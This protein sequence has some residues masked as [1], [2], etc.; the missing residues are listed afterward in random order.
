MKDASK[1]S[2]RSGRSH[3]RRVLLSQEPIPAA[4]PIRLLIV[5]DHAVVLGG[6]EALL[7]A[8][9][10][11]GEIATAS[12]GD[13]ALALCETFLPNLVLMDLRMPGMDGHS[14]IES[15]TRMW[16]QIRIIVFS[17]ND[18]APEIRLAKRNGAAGFMSKSSDPGMLLKLVEKVAAGGTGFPD[19]M[20]Q[21]DPQSCGLSARELEILRHLTRGF[22]NDEI[23]KTLFVSGQTIK[24]HLKHIFP[25][26]GVATRAEAVNRAHELGLL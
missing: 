1:K 21:L 19:Q 13:E 18:S 14:A 7:S 6:L 5:D 20:P 10:F 15:I 2:P 16:P 3:S 17:G 4:T 26:L 25:K 24:G 12:S 23:G 22:S 9:P 11:I 8:V